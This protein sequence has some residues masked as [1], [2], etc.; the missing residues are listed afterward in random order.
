[1]AEGP[2]C[3]AAQHEFNIFQDTAEML[4]LCE[5]HGLASINRTPLAVGFLTGKFDAESQLA[6]DDVG[7]T[8]QSG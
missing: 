8:S 1:M 5:E 2:N 3:T 4:S 7:V 6:A